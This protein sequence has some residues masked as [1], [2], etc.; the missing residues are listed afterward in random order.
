MRSGNEGG[1]V[2]FQET[3]IPHLKFTPL[4]FSSHTAGAPDMALLIVIPCMEE[5]VAPVKIIQRVFEQ[6]G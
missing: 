6:W 2:C 1:A 4:S 3:R 5:E